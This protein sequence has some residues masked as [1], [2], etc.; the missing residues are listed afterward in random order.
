MRIINKYTIEKIVA[1]PV[2]KWNGNLIIIAKEIIDYNFET[3]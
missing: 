3:I 1:H 2:L